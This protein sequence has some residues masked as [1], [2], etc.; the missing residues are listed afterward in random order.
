VA[1]IAAHGMETDPPRGWDA[2]I[3]RRPPQPQGAVGRALNAPPE[4]PLPILHLANFALPSERGD[5]GGN[6]V[7]AMRG[8][9]VFVAVLQHDQGD[10]ATPLFTGR[11]TPWPLAPDDVNPNALPRR[12]DGGAGHQ[13][14]FVAGGRPYCLFVVIAGY[15]Q[16][17]RLVGLANEALATVSFV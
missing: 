6:V 5:Y 15:G 9:G 14:F 3:Y 11:S 7:T 2:V 8:G 16:R 1:R 4:T 17:V 13:S 12:F 10:A